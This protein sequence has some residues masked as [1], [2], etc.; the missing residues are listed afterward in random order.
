MTELLCLV[1]SL[2]QVI[3]SCK[4]FYVTFFVI[5]IM[6][7]SSSLY[8]CS[9]G[10]LSWPCDEGVSGLSSIQHL[11]YCLLYKMFFKRQY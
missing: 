3:R 7:Y 1:T 2:D 4:V 5:F 11:Q 10:P 6:C 9:F 8:I